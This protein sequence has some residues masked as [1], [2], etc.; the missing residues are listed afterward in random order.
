MKLIITTLILMLLFTACTAQESALNL[1][2]PLTTDANLIIQIADITE[3]ALFYPIELDGVAMEVLAV[4]APDGTLRTAFNTCQQC[5]SSGKG[6]FVQESTV[7]VCQNCKRRFRMNQVGL[8]AGGCNPI[9]IT[10]DDRTVTENTITITKETL[11]QAK[12]TFA[13]WK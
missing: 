3:N 2:K 6:Y 11:Q 5:F 9:P 8:E 7:L 13:N 10:N 12:E 1:R 4:K